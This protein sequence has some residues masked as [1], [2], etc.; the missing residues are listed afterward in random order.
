[1]SFFRDREKNR[2][3]RE[4]FNPQNLDL[5]EIQRLFAAIRKMFIVQSPEQTFSKESERTITRFYELA[6]IT[7]QLTDKQLIQT[8]DDLEQALSIHVLRMRSALRLRN[9]K[10]IKQAAE[11]NKMGKREKELFWQILDEIASDY[12]SLP[13]EIIHNNRHLFM[14]D[15][16][17]QSINELLGYFSRE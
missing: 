3:D 15:E 17:S 2:N 16:I 6:N 9:L 4:A 5:N 11:A 10:I 8:I 1:M 13:D 7:K 14:V 12:D